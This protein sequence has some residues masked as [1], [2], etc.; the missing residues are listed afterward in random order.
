MSAMWPRN[1][2]NPNSSPSVE[3]GAQERPVGQVAALHQIRVVAD[4]EVAR[5]EVAVE[6]LDHLAGG[7]ARREDVPGDVGGRHHDLALGVQPAEPEVANQGQ[8]VGLCRVEDL[9]P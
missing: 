3:D 1:W 7:V 8:H 2:K 4:D 5:G 6:R 9:L